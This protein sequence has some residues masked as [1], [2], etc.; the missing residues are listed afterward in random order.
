MICW[1]VEIQEEEYLSWI[2]WGLMPWHLFIGTWNVWKPNT[3]QIV[4]GYP[5]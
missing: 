5:E 1:F 4:L 2:V 3:Y